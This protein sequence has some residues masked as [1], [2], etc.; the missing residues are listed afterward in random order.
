MEKPKITVKT[1]VQASMDKVWEYWTNPEH[2][3]VWNNASDDWYTPK[4]V[5]DLQ[6]GGTFSYTMAARDGS[7]S[8]D[9][10]GVY[11]EVEK[12]QKIAYTLGDKRKVVIEFEEITDGIR[13]TETFEAEEENTL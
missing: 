6:V 4:A 10:Y 2:V 12:N 9:F 11:D 1:L 5:N 3:K 7:V 13:V 8:F